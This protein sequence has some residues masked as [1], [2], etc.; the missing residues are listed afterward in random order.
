MASDTTENGEK[1]VCIHCYVEG[2]VQGVFFRSSTR[3][4]ARSLGIIGFAR[5]LSD[6]RVEIRACGDVQ[7]LETFRQW[8]SRGP[9]HARVTKV[10]CEAAEPEPYLD[11]TI[12]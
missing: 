5:N 6:G 1:T 8:L 12:L 10:Q 4:Q 2:R 3:Q 11:F 7:A 9:E